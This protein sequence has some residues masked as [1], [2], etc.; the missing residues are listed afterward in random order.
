MIVPQ[1]AFHPMYTNTDR[2]IIL[3]TG[4]RGGA[5]SYN[6]S[7]FVERLT[8]ELNT[9][10][11]TSER[12]AHTVLYT[13]YTM[14]SAGMSI[15]PE[16]MEKIDADGTGR[17]FRRTKTEIHNRMTGGKILF[18]GIKTSSGN[19][20]AKLK[21]I[22]GLSVFVVDEGEEW[23]SEDEFEVIRLSIRQKG[24]RN[25]VVIIMN[26]TDSNH[27][28]YRR[29]IK[30]S[31]RIEHFDGVPVQ[32]STHPDVLH[33]HTSYLDNM[34]NLSPEFLAAAAECRENDPKRYAHTFMGQ[35]SD[36]AE[37][38]VFKTV[39]EVDSFPSWCDRVSIGLDF[40]YST[41]KTAAV[42]CGAAGDDLYFKEIF[43][44]T[45]MRAKDIVGEL[46][47][48]NLP[49]YSESADPRLVDEIAL[50]G[51]NIYPVSKGPGSVA[52]GI[53]FMLGKNIHVTKDSFNML[54]EFRNYVWDRDKDGRY[55]NRPRDGD[56]HCIDACRY[57]CTGRLL[58]RVKA[59]S[60]SS[61]YNR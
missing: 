37:G 3:L 18:R 5:K 49:V 52:A 41:D 12:I 35:W 51:I 27:W 20:T 7:T 14:L 1:P 42:L 40:G 46:R 23:T 47:A 19:Q 38:A 56:D 33:I 50:G 31:H 9:D 60:D 21:S 58:G 26:P 8:F 22:H 53:D 28:V 34:G 15:I 59:P 25:L 2:S 43:Y 39:Y 54:D 55:V 32:I 48:W 13:R 44:R 36:V 29:F 61:M 45:G 24:I 11:E 4:G 6:A 57:Y 17:Y 16:V 30:N 10:P